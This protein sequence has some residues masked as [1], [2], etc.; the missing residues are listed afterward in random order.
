[1]NKKCL[2]A[3]GSTPKRRHELSAIKWI[4]EENIDGEINEYS[5]ER[6]KALGKWKPHQLISGIKASWYVNDV[7]QGEKPT[8]TLKDP[9]LLKVFEKRQDSFSESEPKEWDFKDESWIKLNDLF[10]KKGNLCE[11]N[12]HQNV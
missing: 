3:I 7:W 10:K 6:K 5:N 11:T 8:K 1:M 4:L 2:F 9:I 12:S